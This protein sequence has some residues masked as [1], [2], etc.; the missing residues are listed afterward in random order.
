MIESLANLLKLVEAAGFDGHVP[1]IAGGAVRDTLLG[2]PVKDIDVFVYLE[3][4]D[5][6]EVFEHRVRLL[7]LAAG[8]TTTFSS[9]DPAHPRFFDIATIRGSRFDLD[10]QII[11]AYVD[12]IASVNTFDFGICQCYV[13]STGEVVELPACLDDMANQ[14]LTYLGPRRMAG[15]DKA[16]MERI[17]AK[18][19]QLLPVNC[20]PLL[21]ADLVAGGK[22]IDD[23]LATLTE[24]VDA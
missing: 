19:P 9:S 13:L 12:P 22:I 4:E 7:A 6:G 20:T 17:L 21:D 3:P 1:I 8:G 16:H 23:A 11:G 18:Y 24:G 10:I 14:T 5:S 2:G 15:G